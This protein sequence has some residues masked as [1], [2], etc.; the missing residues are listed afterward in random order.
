MQ[1]VT[2]LRNDRRLH[3]IR[4]PDKGDLRAAATQ[5]VRNCDRRIEMT[6]GAA[7]AKT[8]VSAACESTM[9]ADVGDES[10]GDKID[11]QRAAAEGNEW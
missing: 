8:T 3:T 4:R 9:P 6:A 1:I 11:D 10:D 5:R 7:P 2:G